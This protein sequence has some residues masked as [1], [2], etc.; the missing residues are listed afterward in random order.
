MR[1]GS[2]VFALEGEESAY[3]SAKVRIDQCNTMHNVATNS[4]DYPLPIVLLYS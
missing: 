1:H 3:V 4:P 2:V